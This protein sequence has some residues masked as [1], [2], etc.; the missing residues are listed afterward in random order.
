MSGLRVA[1]LF[2]G[3]SVIGLG[4]DYAVNLLGQNSD[5]DNR[6]EYEFAQDFDVHVD[7]QVDIDPEIVVDVVVRNGGRACSFGLDRTLNIPASLQTNS[8]CVLVPAS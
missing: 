4:G 5:D 3:Y 8:P 1:S 2:L 7:V 6:F